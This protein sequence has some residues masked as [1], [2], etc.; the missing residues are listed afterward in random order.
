MVL[1]SKNNFK[2]LNP[3]TPWRPVCGSYV[4]PP[5]PLPRKA[6]PSLV[7]EIGGERILSQG[8]WESSR[9]ASWSVLGCLGR[10]WGTLGALLGHSGGT[11]GTLWGTLGALLGASWAPLGRI[12]KKNTEKSKKSEISG[13]CWHPKWNQNSSKIQVKNRHVFRSVFEPNFDG[14]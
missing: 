9:R 14:F 7:V 3:P 6:P 8:V 2:T 1:F 5:L 4:T 10:S 12:L 11:L 13:P